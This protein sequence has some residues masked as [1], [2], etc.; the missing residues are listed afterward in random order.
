[1]KHDPSGRPYV[2]IEGQFVSCLLRSPLTGNVRE[3]GNILEMLIAAAEDGAPLRWPA[4]LPKPADAV[5]DLREEQP[6]IP[7]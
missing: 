2:E 3:L 6:G 5:L 4:K 7:V 1:V